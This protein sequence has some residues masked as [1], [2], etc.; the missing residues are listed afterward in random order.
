M[1]DR[2]NERNKILASSLRSKKLEK[3]IFSS[4]GA[5]KMEKVLLAMQMKKLL[6]LK[7]R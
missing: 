2:P 3:S 4:S 7:K 5:F 1:L 6:E